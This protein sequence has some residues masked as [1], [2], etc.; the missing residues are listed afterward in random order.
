MQVWLAQH[1]LCGS[2]TQIMMPT[3]CVYYDKADEIVYG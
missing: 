2:D 1:C 3:C